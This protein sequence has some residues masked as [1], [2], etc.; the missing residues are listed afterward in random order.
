MQ[1]DILF[2][3]MP[4][5]VMAIDELHR[6]FARGMQ[7]VASAAEA[8]F[9]DEYGAFVKQAER[10]F[11]IEEHWMEEIDCPLLRTHREQHARVLGALHNV[12]ARVMDGDI[13][14]GREVVGK[15]LPQWFAFH[16]ATMDVALAAMLTAERVD[17]EMP[18][19][20]R[21]TAYVEQ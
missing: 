1:Q 5:G 3:V 4:T 9:E 14:L 7:H 2:S 12:H 21:E 19:T 15:L 10:T 20:E 8:V 13:A 17:V 11:S 16:V 18:P 6:D